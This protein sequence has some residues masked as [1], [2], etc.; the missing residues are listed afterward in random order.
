MV[1]FPQPAGPV[2]I[3]MRRCC[4]E[5]GQEMLESIEVKDVIDASLF[6]AG[7]DIDPKAQ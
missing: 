6:A 2:T 3:H 4:G 7:R 1:D 5:G